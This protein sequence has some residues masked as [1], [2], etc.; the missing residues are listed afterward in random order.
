[1]FSTNLKEFERSFFSRNFGKRLE[2]LLKPAIHGGI[3]YPPDKDR[4]II[5]NFFLDYKVDILPTCFVK[6]FG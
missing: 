1:M 4:N 2:K 6:S 5:H 3:N